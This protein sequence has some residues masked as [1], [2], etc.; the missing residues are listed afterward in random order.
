M[1][2]RLGCPKVFVEDSNSESPKK[3]ASIDDFDKLDLDQPYKVENLI[4][5][6]LERFMAVA[7]EFYAKAKQTRKLKIMM[8]SEKMNEQIKKN[9]LAFFLG[10][11]ESAYEKKVPLFLIIQNPEVEE[12]RAYYKMTPNFD[13]KPPSYKERTFIGVN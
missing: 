11:S 1:N 6:H 9:L 4:G 10:T 5:F 3:A 7:K 2:F 8:T 13:R 12:S